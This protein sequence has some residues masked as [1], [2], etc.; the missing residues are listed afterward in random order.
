MERLNP[1][2]M[3]SHGYRERMMRIRIRPREIDKDSK[4]YVSPEEILKHQDEIADEQER[5]AEQK[6]R[7]YDQENNY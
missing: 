5:E 2:S 3:P 4:N 7:L 6:A 1:R